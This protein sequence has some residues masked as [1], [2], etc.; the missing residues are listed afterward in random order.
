MNTYCYVRE[1]IL[2]IAIRPAVSK[3]RAIHVYDFDNTCEHCQTWDGL[4]L[5]H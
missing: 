2:T 3:I 1:T 4:R 5:D